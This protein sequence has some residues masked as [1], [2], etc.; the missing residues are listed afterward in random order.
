MRIFKR[1]HASILKI[2]LIV[3]CIP[4]ANGC[5][6]E[7]AIIG[8][9]IGATAVLGSTPGHQLEQVY[10]L[11]MFDP[12][13][14]VPPT[15]YRVTVRGQASSFS[16]MKFGS[17]WVPANLVDSLN[18]R[19]SF[20]N[21]SKSNTIQ[22]QKGSP[23]EMAALKTGRRMVMFGPEG[24]R[25]APTDHRL[26]IVMGA[27]PEEYFKAMDSVLGD[28]SQA[29]SELSQSKVKDIFIQTVLSIKDEQGSL[30]DLKHKVELENAR[31]QVRVVENKVVEERKKAISAAEDAKKAADR[32]DV[33]QKKASTA[34]K[35]ATKAADAAKDAKDTADSAVKTAEKASKAAETAKFVADEATQHSFAADVKSESAKEQASDSAD[36]ARIS[37]D[38]AKESAATAQTISDSLRGSK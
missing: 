37:A 32:A 3:F 21:A 11:G 7:G 6:T 16:L 9:A 38:S 26:V 30:K 10:Y 8:G 23:Q 27:S 5:S 15:V 25:E 13:E 28:I 19:M 34:E 2:L 29:Q 17:G 22:F 18:T 36:Q 35:T 33:A 14:Q 1:I 12:Q 4:F 24:F 20:G 31:Q